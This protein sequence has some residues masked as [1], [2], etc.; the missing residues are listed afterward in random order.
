[1]DHIKLES[2]WKEHLESEFEQS[3]MIQLR[4]FFVQEIQKEKEIYPHPSLWFKA[5]ELTPFEEVKV[6]LVG[7]DPY[8]GPRQAHGLCFSVQTDVPFPPSLKNIFTELKN[9]LGLLYPKQGCLIPWA[10][11]GVLL[12]NSVLTVRRG[13]AGSHQNQ[14]W[15]KFTDKILSLLNEKKENLV[16][17]LWGSYALMKGQFLNP[18]KHLVLKAPHPSPLSAHRGF[19]GSKHFSKTNEYLTSKKKKCIDW[20]LSN[21]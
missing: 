9:D 11:Q 4:K 3:Y 6:V 2:S 5:L 8:H 7:Q 18:Q 1:M 14:G 20:S 17:I 10:Q 21:V 12:L 15:E 13:Q 16:F 19:F